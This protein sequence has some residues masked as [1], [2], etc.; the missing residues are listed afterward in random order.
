MVEYYSLLARIVVFFA[1]VGFV[2]FCCVVLLL[3]IEFV[4]WLKSKNSP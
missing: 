2:F 4:K 1:V 3:A